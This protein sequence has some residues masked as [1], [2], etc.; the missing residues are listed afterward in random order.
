MELQKIMEYLVVFIIVALYQWLFIPILKRKIGYVR[1]EGTLF[2]QYKT[3]WQLPFEIAVIVAMVLC[4]GLLTPVMDLWSAIFIPM[5]F[6]VILVTRGILEKKYEADL[7]HY[8]I[9]FVQ[10]MAVV[11]AFLAILVYGMLIT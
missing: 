6:V 4:I 8:L 5:G 1:V 9:S 2:Y 10:A 3:K 11:I 7:R